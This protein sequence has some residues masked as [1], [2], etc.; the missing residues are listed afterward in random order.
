VLLLKE[1]REWMEVLVK[2]QRNDDDGYDGQRPAI[3]EL[4]TIY[5]DY[6]GVY[7]DRKGVKCAAILGRE[8]RGMHASRPRT[9]AGQGWRGSTLV[10]RRERTCSKRL[11]YAWPAVFR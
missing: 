11:G 1:E 4:K 9:M 7:Y 3:E 6:D 8:R 2:R 10:T 5:G